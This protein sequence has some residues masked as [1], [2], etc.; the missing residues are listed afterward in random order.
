MS[1]IERVVNVLRDAIRNTHKWHNERGM[2]NLPERGVRCALHH[3]SDDCSCS[4]PSIQYKYPYILNAARARAR[5]PAAAPY[6][7]ERELVHCAYA[8]PEL[9][10]ATRHELSKQNNTQPQRTGQGSTLQGAAVTQQYP[11]RQQG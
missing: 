3:Q 8:P 7:L 4:P 2:C 9:Q 11:S 10:G 1:I 6:T 5:R